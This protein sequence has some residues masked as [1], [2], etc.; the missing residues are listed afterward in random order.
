MT[1]KNGICFKQCGFYGLLFLFAFALRNVLGIICLQA[2]VLVGPQS[3]SLKI[4]DHCEHMGVD[5]IPILQVGHMRRDTCRRTEVIAEQLKMLIEVPKPSP[6]SP[7]AFPDTRL[8]TRE[9]FVSGI[10][11]GTLAVTFRVVDRQPFQRTTTNNTCAQMT[12]AGA[13]AEVENP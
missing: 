2:L 1:Q 10:Y 6:I 8:M 13:A 3:I 4:I 11:P 9:E 7:F 5:A 12:E